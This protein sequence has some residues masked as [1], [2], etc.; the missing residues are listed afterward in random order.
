[1]A[2]QTKI[3]IVG[4]SGYL[5]NQHSTPVP[6]LLGAAGANTGNLLFQYATRRL[7]HQD[8]CVVNIGALEKYRYGDL[9][10][11]IHEFDCAII[12]AANHL[13]ANADWTGFN[14]FLERLPIPLIVLGL[15][16]QAELAE[17]PSDAARALK[18]NES[19]K[20]MADIFADKACFI[21]TRG[22]FTNEVCELLG[23]KNVD[24]LGCPSLMMNPQRDLGGRMARYLDSVQ[25]GEAGTEFAVAAEAPGALSDHPLKKLAEQSL[26]TLAIDK[27]GYYIQQSGGEVTVAF[28]TAHQCEDL[29]PSTSEW[30]KSIVAPTITLP[31]LSE[32]L[33]K[34]G[35][36]FF[37]AGDWIEFCSTLHVVVGQRIHGCLAAIAGG[38]PA[39]VIRHDSRVSE[40]AE[41]MHLPSVAME[42]FATGKVTSL[43]SLIDS[44]HFDA[45]AFNRFRGHVARRLIQ[46]F[47]E[48][49]LLYNEKLLSLAHI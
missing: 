22:R 36:V 35:R 14:S 48:R 43:K 31:E 19:V 11:Q 26:L 16:A 17:T 44:V 28:A 49:K 15:G 47:E 27:K 23:M 4:S 18:T 10:S 42:T 9:T 20:R 7:F 25:R 32:Y 21:G 24:A 38:T 5:C 12:P 45:C 29:K 34:Y 39:I 13:R 41:L 40:L 2:S 33:A 30:F 8:Q 37:S 46:V 1:V 6:L 3:L